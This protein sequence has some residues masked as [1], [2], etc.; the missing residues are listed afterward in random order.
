MRERGRAEERKWEPA[1]KRSRE[2]TNA[3]LTE[4]AGYP[5]RKL[6]ADDPYHAWNSEH[7]GTASDAAVTSSHKPTPTYGG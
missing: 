5:T 3:A 7:G 1:V 4:E 6:G 2:T